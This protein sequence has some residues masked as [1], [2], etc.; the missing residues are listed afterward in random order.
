MQNNNLSPNAI[1]LFAIAGGPEK[2][3]D[4]LDVLESLNDIIIEEFV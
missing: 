1:S 4:V 2:G 3:R